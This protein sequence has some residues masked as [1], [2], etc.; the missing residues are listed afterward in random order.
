M[1]IANGRLF[2]DAATAL[3]PLLWTKLL[4]A[5]LGIVVLGIG[6]AIM[7][8]LG[9][10]AVK[11]LARHRTDASKPA[12]ESWYQRPLDEQLPDQGADGNDDDA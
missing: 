11:R 2:A 12:D 9:G 4:L 8:V 6:M 3:P 10:R 1:R 7:V 5:L